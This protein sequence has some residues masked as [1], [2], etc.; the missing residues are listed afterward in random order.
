MIGQPEQ[1]RYWE[2]E[3]SLTSALSP[4]LSHSHPRPFRPHLLTQV[5]SVTS[6]TERCVPCRFIT[7]TFADSGPLSS[8]RQQ[9][10][11]VKA[12]SGVHTVRFKNELERNITIKLGY[13][14]AKVRFADSLPLI[15]RKTGEN[16]AL[17]LI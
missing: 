13:A 7:T 3:R 15:P 5:P 8:F 1:L 10:Q 11:T 17:T 4:R 9:S 6:R 12:I 16:S 2:E 14:N